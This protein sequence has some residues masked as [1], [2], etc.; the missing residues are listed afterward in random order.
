[1]GILWTVLAV[2]FA[3]LE[4]ATVQMVSIWF[5]G[6]AV[7]GLVAYLCGADNWLQLIVFAAVS[8]LL[9]IVTKPFVRKM[10]TEKEERTNA[11]SLLGT[12]TMITEAVDNLAETGAAKINGVTWSVRSTG[13]ERI[14]E[15]EIVTIERIEGVKLIVRKGD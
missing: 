14:P 10:R 11:D 7:G 2:A 13:G 8:G 15:G 4:M 9:L 3:V 12:K 5:A 6:G 1:M